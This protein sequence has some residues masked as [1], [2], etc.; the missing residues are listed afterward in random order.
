MRL[1]AGTAWHQS[2]SGSERTDPDLIPLLADK[3]CEL[4]Q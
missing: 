4:P 3:S 1:A 2:E